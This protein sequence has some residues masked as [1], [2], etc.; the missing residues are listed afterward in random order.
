MPRRILNTTEVEDA[1]WRLARRAVENV[2]DIIEGE[3]A[4][5][6][7]SAV[8]MGAMYTEAQRLRE[9]IYTLRER[10]AQTAPTTDSAVPEESGPR[11]G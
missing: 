11:N 8:T 1:A 9:R 10:L 2:L 6:D 7:A 3:L 5:T 4:W